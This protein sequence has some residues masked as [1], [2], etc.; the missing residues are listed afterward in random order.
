MKEKKLFFAIVA[1]ILLAVVTL[2]SVVGTYAK[3]TTS[4]NGSSIARV[5][6]WAWNISGEDINA[7]TTTYKLDLFTTVKDSDNSTDETNVTKGTNENIIAP[8]TS[9]SFNIVITNNSEVDA[10]YKYDITETNDNNVPIEYSLDKTSWKTAQ[11]MSKAY[12][13]I[14]K[15]ATDNSATIYWRWA[16]G[17]GSTDAT[18]T[19][20]GFD[21]T[22][23]VTINADLVL[24]QVD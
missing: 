7:G 18:D 13:D 9:G 17:T 12:T 19:A 6:K 1:L 5:A 24:E 15:G 14:A 2:F 20:I 21:G 23:T 22:A 10:R 4:L 3:Y 11:D 8:G 16:F